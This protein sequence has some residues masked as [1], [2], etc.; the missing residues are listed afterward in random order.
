MTFPILALLTRRSNALEH[1][2][3][4]LMVISV[5]PTNVKIGMRLLAPSPQPTLVSLS[6]IFASY[7]KIKLELIRIQNVL[8]RQL[9]PQLNSNAHRSWASTNGRTKNA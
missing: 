7:C 4:F 3:V 6:L 1:L 8:L 5:L 9:D 2:N